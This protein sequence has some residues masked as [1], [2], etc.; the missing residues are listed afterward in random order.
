MLAATEQSCFNGE[1]S[2][3][4]CRNDDGL[5]Q[6]PCRDISLALIY[7]VT[8]A[9]LYCL[10]T[11]GIDSA[12]HS[13]QQRFQMHDPTSKVT[14]TV[15]C[16]AQPEV[17]C[18]ESGYKSTQE[19]LL[20]FIYSDLTSNWIDM[21]HPIGYW[22]KNTPSTIDYINNNLHALGRYDLDTGFFWYLGWPR[23]I[24][25]ATI[26]TIHLHKWTWWPSQ[27]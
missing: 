2:L 20:K 3:S 11:Q 6:V 10:S 1:G 18:I 27:R 5:P 21:C 14:T 25:N 19:L 8:Y 7:D 9:Y 24:N 12:P 17:W 23:N 15:I 4:R 26:S 22:I 16:P 13:H